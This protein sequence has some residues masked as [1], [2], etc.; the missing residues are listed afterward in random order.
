LAKILNYS[1]ENFTI[2]LNNFIYNNRRVGVDI[3]EQVKNIVSNVE[4]NGDKA[5]NELTLKYDNY[6]IAEEGILVSKNDISHA[7]DSCDKELISAL[8][9]AAERISAFHKLQ[10]PKDITYIDESNVSLSSRWTAL[11]SVGLYV[12]GGKASYPS[13][14]IMTAI[15]A[16][17]AKVPEI[18]MCVPSPNGYLN[19]AVL[20]AAKI[21]GIE[22]IYK[23]GGAQA[24]AAMAYGSKSV[25]S[26]NKIFGP[27]NAWVAEAKRQLFG[28]VGIDMVA[29]PSEIL[30]IADGESNPKWIATDLLSQAEHDADAQSILITD[31]LD[32]AKQVEV[33]IITLIKSLE[34]AEIAKTSW[35]NNGMIIIVKNWDQSIEIANKIAPEHLEISMDNPEFISDKIN[36]AGSIFL[37]RYVPEAIGDYIAGPNHVLPTARTARFSSGIST[38]DYMRRT[39]LIK[40]DLKSLSAIAP[41]AIKIAENEG[42]GAHALS[43]QIRIKNTKNEE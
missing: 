28:K 14:V 2:L 23:I 36:N 9:K 11:D 38:L 40:C 22:N 16:K 21:S 30:I 35:N 8:E 13:S 41:S 5:I 39:S 18:C 6:N 43:M 37:G 10:T 32:F 25:K 19:P 27:G 17:I 33:E 15:P 4:K 7:Y 26:V 31:S 34:R 20:V 24:I 42:L 29:G 3:S 1:N 12:P